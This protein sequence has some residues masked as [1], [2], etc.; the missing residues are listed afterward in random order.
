MNKLRCILMICWI[1]LT[2][3]TIPCFAEI[4]KWVDE[5]GVMHFTDDP[6][7][8][9]R[10]PQSSSAQSQPMTSGKPTY[11]S[12]LKTLF[13]TLTIRE[14]LSNKDFKKLNI[15][16]SD[17]QKAY[18]KD[19][20]NEDNLLD[21]YVAFSVSDAY[22]EA[23]LNEW[24]KSHPD[25]Y[26][27]Y[28]AR[29]SYF[30][31]LG[32][33]SRGG[34]WANDTSDKQIE[35][36]KS[37]FSKAK[38]DIEQVLKIKPDHIVPYY[39]LINIYKASGGDGEVKVIV[40][41]ALEKCPNSFRIRSTYLLS[42]TPRWGGTY[43][44][45]DR[46]ATESQKYA[47]K[48]SRLKALKGYV[49]YDAGNMQKLSKN[50]GVALE[51][52]NKALTFG[53]LAM[54]YEERADIYD[55]SEKY[56]EALK[57]INIAID[58]NP[59]N[60]DFYSKRA[61]LFGSKKMMPEALKDIEI[62]D[63][64]KPNDEFIAKQKKW[65]ADKFVYSG[66]SQQKTKNL[67]GAIED[68]NAAIQANP[69]DAYS[70]YRRA[71]AFIDKK[72][73]A[74][75]FNDLKKAIELDP[76]EFDFYLLMDWLLAQKSDW[77]GITNFWGKYIALNPNNDRAYLERGGAFF[78]KGDL[79]SAVADAKRAADLGNAEGQKMYDRYKGQAKK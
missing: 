43:E 49:F 2:F 5:N 71:R 56:D 13:P 51:L 75:A 21:A 77:D 27:P 38:Q 18:E 72:D 16:L 10:S 63:Q 4:Y 42:I 14:M 8:I 22:Y 1:G 50:Y 37:Y 40:K 76:N 78:H 7:N 23:L 44:E 54:F 58:M 26:Q 67:S 17:Y 57:D 35:G 20:R 12:Q 31:N 30:Y 61:R 32:W 36:M 55:D 3:A 62:A 41:K 47:F 65:I 79:A 24:V 74:S 48:N 53:D 39:F 11:D 68:Y 25:S 6:S 70:Y 45:M 33:K 66:H 60:P 9:P 15:A 59:Q 28:L 52:L 29:A 73:L 64:L 34:K 46:F 19:V 69:N